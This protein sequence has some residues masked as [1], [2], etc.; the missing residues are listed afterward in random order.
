MTSSLLPRTAFMPWTPTWVRPCGFPCFRA[1][2]RRT[3]AAVP[4]H[5]GAIYLLAMSNDGS[6][7]YLH[8][9]Q[10]LDLTSSTELLGGKLVQATYPGTGD[11]S[12]GVT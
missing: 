2:R 11:N 10:A 6:G 7:N 12:D 3:T 1:K 4:G 8:R 9:L 5:N